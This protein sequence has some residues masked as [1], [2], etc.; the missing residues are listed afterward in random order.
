MNFINS[1]L[2]LAKNRPGDEASPVVEL[3]WNYGILHRNTIQFHSL[4]DKQLNSYP[5]QSLLQ[6]QY[7]TILPTPIIQF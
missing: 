1:G 6:L 4:G 2:I 3:V 7:S 5:I